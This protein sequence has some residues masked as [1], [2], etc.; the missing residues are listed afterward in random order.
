MLERG[1][2]LSV[3]IVNYNSTRLLR[4]CLASLAAS[5]IADRLEVIVI[6][7][8]SKDFDQ[9]T[10][11]AE[12]PWVSI[13]PQVVNTTWT[14]GNNIAF[15]ASTAPLILLLNPDTEVEAE[16][17]ENAISH[18]RSDDRLAGAGAYLI[19][20]DGGLQR[21]YRRLPDI[22]DVPTIFFERLFRRT[23]RGRRYLMLD[24][25]FDLPA[26]VPQPPGAFLMFRR[27]DVQ[28]HLLDP[29]YCNFVSDVALCRHLGGKGRLMVF[30][31]VRVLH[32]RAGAGVGTS[33][34]V[35]RARLYRDLA[36]GVRHYF[37]EAP[38]TSR[39]LIGLLIVA[40]V[41]TRFARLAIARPRTI[42]VIVWE[43]A[44][45]AIGRRPIY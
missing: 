18:L 12:F 1:P 9:R 27:S 20:A 4:R 40:Y 7:N 16:A 19:G 34:P 41:T 11:R 38:I 14:G 10:M 26:V 23:S 37:A 29:A 21:Y 28:R 5:T 31:D 44:P 24:E 8:G 13:M 3:L 17:L 25:P 22:R 42:G 43:M 15:A 36:W 39:A 30:P 33:E 35:V 32:S 2:E 45:A 6:D